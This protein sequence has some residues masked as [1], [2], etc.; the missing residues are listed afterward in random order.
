MEER[1]VCPRH[2]EVNIWIVCRHVGR[3][4]ADTIVFSEKK[5]ALCFDC[6]RDFEKLTEPDVAGMCEECLKDFTAKLMIQTQTFAN[7]KNRILGIEHLKGN[8][9]KVVDRNGEEER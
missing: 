2:G 6:A 9:N 5:D 8:R 4:D 3:G 7:L 1:G